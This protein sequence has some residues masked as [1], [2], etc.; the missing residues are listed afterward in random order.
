MFLKFYNLSN[1]N[2]TDLNISP[3]FKQKD[4]KRKSKLKI[5]KPRKSIIQARNKEIR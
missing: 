5:L 2:H 3:V 1:F 4:I